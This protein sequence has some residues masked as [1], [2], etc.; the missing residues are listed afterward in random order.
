M[1]RSRERQDKDKGANLNIG[2]T[3]VRMVSTRCVC[4]RV[5]NYCLF[6]NRVYIIRM[7]TR[8][9]LLT[10][11][12]ALVGAFVGTLLVP[13]IGTAIGVIVGILVGARF[14]R[15]PKDEGPATPP[16]GPAM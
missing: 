8:A 10:F 1:G 13:G 5:F 14:A 4:H 7:R 16:T 9:K 3:I 15:H 12:G 11:V 2:N 6:L